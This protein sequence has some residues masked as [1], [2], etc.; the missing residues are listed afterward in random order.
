MIRILIVDDHRLFR[1]GVIRMLQEGQGLQIIGEAESG[2][3]AVRMVRDQRP[4]IVLM[5][6]MMPGIGG[7]E[8]TT[9]IVRMNLDIKVIA[10]TG[11]SAPPFPMQMLKA[12]ASGYLTKGVS[13]DELHTAIRKVFL[14]QRYVSS[15]I[16]Q[17]L[18]VSAFDDNQDSP[19]DSL[20][21]REMQ[22][23]LMV[24][25]CH[26][27]SDISN[28]LHLSPKTVN[29]YRYRIFEKLKVSSDV[30]LALM[31]VRH[32]MVQPKPGSIGHHA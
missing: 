22:I 1:S 5:D 8:A 31:A 6:I 2:E 9:R 21:N 19:F 30:E 28:N 7:L 29:S 24:I 4:N 14:G 17:Q 20:S 32:G 11:C 27:V 12:G 10:L 23:M 3:A 25:A 26:K 13:A 16:A 15:D 18:A